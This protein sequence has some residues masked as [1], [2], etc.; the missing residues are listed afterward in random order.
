MKSPSGRDNHVILV[1]LLLK[2]RQPHKSLPVIGSPIRKISPANNL[3]AKIRPARAAAG[4]G[5][6]LPVNCR[7]RLF[8]GGAIL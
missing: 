2:Y 6:F 4:R 5:G 7:G 1:T 3:P 8:G